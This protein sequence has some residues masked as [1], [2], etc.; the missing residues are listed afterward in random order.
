MKKIN[1]D[2]LFGK[3]VSLSEKFHQKIKI[4]KPAKQLSKK[5]WPKSWKTVH[6]KGYP[7]LDEIF[8]PKPILQNNLSLKQSLMKRKSSRQF[9]EKTLPINKLSSLLYYSAGLRENKPP[10]EANR[11]YPSAGARYP[12]E[13][14]LLS[15]N[16]DL[17]KGLYHYYLKNHSLEKLLIFDKLDVKRYIFH[18]WFFDAACFI[19]ISSVFKRTTVKYGDRGYCFTLLEAGHLGQNFYL[20]SSA[21]DIACCGIGGFVEH[22][23]ENLLDIDGVNESIVY[24]LALG[25]KI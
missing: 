3:P 4:K 9:S 5:L 15:L 6:F 11:F 19:I 8:L 20:V 2:E 17:P 21:L 7:R 10:W 23:L 16:T 22:E 1:L 18:E 25:N 13:V 12:L 24:I 14:Y